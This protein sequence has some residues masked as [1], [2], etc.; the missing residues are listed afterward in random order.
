[1][2]AHRQVVVQILL[3][4]FTKRVQKVARR[5]PQAFDGV[6]MNLVDTIAIVIPCP[7]FLPMTYSVVSTLEPVVA[8]PFICVTSGVSFG[9]AMY[10]LLQRFALGMVTNAQATL[11][12]MTPHGSDNGKPIVVVRAMPA[13]LVSAAPGRI[14]GIGVFL[15]F[16]PPRSETSQPSPCRAP[17]TP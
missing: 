16:L 12:T 5:G 13:L 11:P 14:K 1:M 3:V 15:S 2:F 6:G 9:V 10:V 8:L 17:A 4:D 7:F